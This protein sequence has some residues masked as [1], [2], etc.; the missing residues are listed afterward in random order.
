M[1]ANAIADDTSANATGTATWFRVVDGDANTVMDGDVTV[2]AASPLGDL[3]MNTTSINSG[4]T[5]S[6]TQFDLTEGNA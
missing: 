5:V 1:S 3:I 4:A 6:V 2:A